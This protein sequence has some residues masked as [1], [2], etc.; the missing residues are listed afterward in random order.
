MENK[1]CFIDEGVIDASYGSYEELPEDSLGPVKMSGNMLYE[2]Q[3]INGE[4][5]IV[6]IID[7]GINANHPEFEGR[8]IDGVNVNSSYSDPLDYNDDNKHGTHC[9]GL[10]CGK[11][12]GVA[13]G[14]KLLVIKALDREGGMNKPS[15]IIKALDYARKWSGPKGERVDIISMSLSGTKMGWGGATIVNNMEKAIQACVKQNILVVCSMG[16]TGGDSVRYPAALDDVVAVCAVDVDKKQAKFTTSGSHADVCQVGVNVISASHTGG[17]ISLSGTSM[18]TPIVAG[19]AA[20]IKSKYKNTV[21]EEL[22]ERKLYEALK[23]HTIDIGIEGT[24]KYFGAGFCTLNALNLSVKVFNGSK[25]IVVNGYPRTIDTPCTVVNGR[26]IIPFRH[27]V[28]LT[29]GYCLYDEGSDSA[30]F[31]W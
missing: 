10:I 26:F 21:K 31:R 2:S 29:G 18:S 30:T 23:H 17:Y 9:A 6:A 14:A 15:D 5:V 3:G 13:K 24:D 1:Y 4:G 25:T 27:F 28:E 7:T 12:A 22:T 8:I 11:Y 16:N 20:L 19:I